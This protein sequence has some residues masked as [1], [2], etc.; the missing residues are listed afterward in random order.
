M[1]RTILSG[2]AGAETVGGWITRSGIVISGSFARS[3]TSTTSGGWGISSKVTTS[4]IGSTFAGLATF[5]F[6]MIYLSNKFESPRANFHPNIFGRLRGSQLYGGR[7]EMCFMEFLFV[8]RRA[9][10]IFGGH[11]AKA[12]CVCAGS[13]QM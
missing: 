11:Y 6:G 9:N 4:T 1:T 5:F 13:Y 2:S 8:A 12:A 10:V 7:A 3:T